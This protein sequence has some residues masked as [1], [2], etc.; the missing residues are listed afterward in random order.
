MITREINLKA[1]RIEIQRDI[2]V[3]ISED[4]CEDLSKL[5]LKIA[6]TFGKE[7]IQTVEDVA[8]CLKKSVNIVQPS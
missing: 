5:R 7:E 1:A 3:G 8:N 6:G 2:L 4:F